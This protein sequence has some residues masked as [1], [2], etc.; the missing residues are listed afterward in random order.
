LTAA[1]FHY[2]AQEDDIKMAIRWL[3][4]HAREF[5]A[6]PDSLFVTG[7][8]AGAVLSAEIGVDL[9]WL[10]EA[11]I[12]RRILKGIAPVSG[13]YDLRSVADMANYVPN[14]ELAE[15]ASPL[16]HIRAPVSHA[17]IAF[18]T[19]NEEEDSYS[20]SA[21]EFADALRAHGVHVEV[22]VLKGSGHIATAMALGTP[23]SALS[24]AV[25]AM[26]QGRE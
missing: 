7:H 8:S 2:P 15:R 4:V 12:D 25:L 16:L 6:D 14:A 1:G 19:D 10:G 17:V 9:D 13:P 20:P 21:R 3:H 18:G 26:I 24:K 11:G 5:G 23:D 22:V